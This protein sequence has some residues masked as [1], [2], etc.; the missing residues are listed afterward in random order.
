VAASADRRKGD[1]LLDDFHRSVDHA[2]KKPRTVWRGADRGSTLL[3]GQIVR[4]IGDM[5]MAPPG[6]PRRELRPAVGIALTLTRVLRR[7]SGA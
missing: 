4:Q 6:G 2:M 1:G 5:K 3:K 7:F